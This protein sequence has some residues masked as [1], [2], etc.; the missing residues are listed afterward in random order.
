[1][2]NFFHFVIKFP[3]HLLKISEKSEIFTEVKSGD[4]YNGK[5]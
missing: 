5:L 2:Y 3:L 4:T 1:M